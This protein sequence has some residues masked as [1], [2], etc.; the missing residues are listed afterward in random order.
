MFGRKLNTLTDYTDTTSDLLSEDELIE[1]A[2]TLAKIVYPIT[3]FAV[4]YNN[5]MV[6]SFSGAKKIV[7]NF[8]PGSQ[9]MMKNLNW[10]EKGDELYVGPY[11]GG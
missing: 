2:L 3:S 9:V 1:R 8:K 10:T 5:K 7:K 6:K 11:T 4:D